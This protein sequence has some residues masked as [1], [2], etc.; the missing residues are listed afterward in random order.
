[1]PSAPRCVALVG[2]YLSGKTSLLEAMLFASG[3]SMKL[4][5][6]LSNTQVVD[7]FHGCAAHAANQGVAIAAYQR[8]GDGLDAHRAIEIGVW[9]LEGHIARAVDR[10]PVVGGGVELAEA[11]VFVFAG[12]DVGVKREDGAVVELNCAAFEVAENLL[13]FAAHLG[14]SVRRCSGVCFRPNPAE[15]RRRRQRDRQSRAGF[16]SL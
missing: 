5:S 11:F 10:V 14:T 7:L 12:D 15:Y 13:G 3:R 9:N 1:M 2:P 8:I 4:R 6:S 16:L